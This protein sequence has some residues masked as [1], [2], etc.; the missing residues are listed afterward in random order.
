MIIENVKVDKLQ[1]TIVPTFPVTLDQCVF[2]D[3]ETV[4]QT[5]ELTEL[6]LELQHCWQIK[7]TTWMDFRDNERNQV[8][9][10]LQQKL[11]V[12]SDGGLDLTRDELKQAL[13]DVKTDNVEELYKK[14]AGLFP[15]YGKIICISIGFIGKNGTWGKCSFVGDEFELLVTFVRMMDNI[16]KNKP[17]MYIVGHNIS[18]FDL[19]YLFKRLSINGI[20][21]PSCLHKAFQKPWEKKVIDTRDEWR[22]GDK[23]GD[24]TL[25]T[26][27]TVLGIP[28]SKDDIT[29]AEMTPY[30]YSKDF[31][32]NR[33]VTYCE[34][35]VEATKE[36]FLALQNVKKY[37]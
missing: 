28:T 25:N 19:P 7:S 17:N 26:V 33:V 15:E 9:F 13:Q 34:K 29:G 8:I 6:S 20:A 3:I 27:C 35:D 31:D 4:S 24:N 10:N 14:R 11:K 32:I 18:L 12:M 16:E 1:P 5:H 37:I 30:Y 22:A 21:C 23:N 2:I 36:V